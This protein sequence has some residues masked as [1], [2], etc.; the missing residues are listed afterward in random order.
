MKRIYIA[1]PYTASTPRE[2]QKNVDLAVSLGCKLI[3]SGW[4]PFIPHLSHYVWLHPEGDFDRETWMEIDFKWLE[5]SDAFFYIGSSCGAD[6]ELAIAMNM[7]IP[8]YLFIGDV[9]E[10]K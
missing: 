5:V 8:I 1:G 4:A 6:A 3:R 10:V 9:P 7:K 2:A